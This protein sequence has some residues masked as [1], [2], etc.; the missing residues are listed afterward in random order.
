MGR[1]YSKNSFEIVIK[2]G[3][4]ENIKDVVGI[5]II[6]AIILFLASQE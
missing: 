2:P 6:A 1:V 4:E 3:S 5:A